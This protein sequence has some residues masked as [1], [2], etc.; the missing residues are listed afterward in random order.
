MIKNTFLGLGPMSLELINSLD[1]FSRKYKKKLMLICSR[2]QIETKKLGNG[3]VNNFSTESFAKFIRSKKNKNLIMCRDHGGPFKRDSIPK[4]LKT[5]IEN[6]KLSY[7]DD[8]KNN[9]KIIHIDTSACGK[10]KYEIAKELINFCENTAKISNK[11]IYYEFGCEEHGV[12]TDFKKFNEDIKFYSQIKNRQ[13]IVCQTGSLVKSIFQVGQFDIDTVKQMKI[14]AKNNGILLK[15]HNC[16]YLNS[17]QIQL[18]KYYG[19]DAINVA[20][21]LGVIQTNLLYNLAKKFCFDKEIKKFIKIT[22][23]KGKWKKWVYY[24]ENNLIK[25]FTSGHYY[26]CLDE[27]FELKYKISKKINFQKVLN[28]DVENNLLKYY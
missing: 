21:E 12:L 14:I 8:I 26:F 20:P 17:Q 9:F 2:N 18:R 13:Y 23:S 25:F 4:N 16:D 22:L 28:K 1:F 15:E 3:Y 6:S 7:E 27:Y 10:M 19:I 11:K 24:K 5:E